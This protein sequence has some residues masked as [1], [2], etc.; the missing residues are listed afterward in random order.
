MIYDI[1]AIRADFPILDFVVKQRSI[2]THLIAAILGSIVYRII[3]ALALDNNISASSM[4][5]ISSL[6]VIVIISIPLLKSK[7]KAIMTTI[8]NDQGGSKA[9]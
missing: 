1:D 5:L 9:C 6:I 7:I 8:N 2:G 3:I 4:K